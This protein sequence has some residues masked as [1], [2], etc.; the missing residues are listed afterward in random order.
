MDCWK[1]LKKDWK[2]KK[3]NHPV[4]LPLFNFIMEKCN[5]KALQLE[6]EVSLPFHIPMPKL[7]PAPNQEN[8]AN[9]AG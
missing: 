4:K 2:K 9:Y 3:F 5:L 8:P 6:E 1:V 7:A